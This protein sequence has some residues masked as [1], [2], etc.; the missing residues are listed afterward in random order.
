M[1]ASRWLPNKMTSESLIDKNVKLNVT[2]SSR[3]KCHS[4]QAGR[5]RISA[6]RC[7]LGSLH[8][9]QGGVA[10]DKRLSFDSTAVPG[11]EKPGGRSY[12]S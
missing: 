6:S 5:A 11:R 9:L 12:S 8:C 2:P 1:L 4:R 3:V 10:D 7:P